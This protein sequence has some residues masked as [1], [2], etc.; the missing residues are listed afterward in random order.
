MEDNKI[1]ITDKDLYTIAVMRYKK[2]HK[3]LSDNNIFPKEWNLSADYRTKIMIIAEAIKTNA[4]VEDTKLYKK[5][6]KK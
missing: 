1:K 3:E 2:E 5:I 6:F 4:L